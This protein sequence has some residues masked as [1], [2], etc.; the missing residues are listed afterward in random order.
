MESVS[1][2]RMQDGT[3]EEYEFLET[4]D[5][6]VEFCERYD[7]NCFDPNYNS[8]S[9]AFFR[10]MLQEVFSRDPAFGERQVDAQE[11]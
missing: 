5:E 4:L 7:E 8:E 2:V 9:L 1:F 6:A 3:S 11:V 10:P